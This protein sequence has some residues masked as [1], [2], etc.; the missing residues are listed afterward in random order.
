MNGRLHRAR[1]MGALCAVLVAVPLMVSAGGPGEA[2]PSRPHAPRAAAGSPNTVVVL[3]DDMRAHELR[4]LPRTRNWLARRGVRFDAAY[5]PTPLCCPAR[6][7]LLT[8][9]YAHNTGVYD[10]RPGGIRPGGV[11]AFDDDRTVATELSRRGIETG[12]IGKYLNQY[13]GLWIPPGWTDWR[14][15]IDGH[16]AYRT[17]DGER[18][19]GRN[20]T[21]TY[22]GRTVYNVNGKE[23]TIRG[24]E[25]TVQTNLTTRFIRRNA[26]D[27]FFL[28]V[29]YLAPH[30]TVNG[31]DGGG[32][33]VPHKSHAHDFDGLKAPRTKAFNEADVRDKPRRLR[34]SPMKR[35]KQE[36]LDRAAEARAE[37]LQ[38]VDDGMMAIRRTLSRQ[39]ILRR[40]NVVFVSD[41]GFMLGEHRMSQEK[42]WA[43]E[44]SARVPL[45]MAGPD[46]PGKGERRQVPVGL[47]DLPSTITDWHGLGAMPGADGVPLFNGRLPR[48]DIL[49]QGT[50]ETQADISYTGLR[51]R[52][53]YKYVEYGYGG[54]ELYDLRRD[55]EELRNLAR[56]KSHRSLRARLSHRLDALRD[57]AGRDCWRR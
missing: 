37:T 19:T 12:H 56:D 42:I 45:L 13:R 28:L 53:G 21:S 34:R 6:A 31:P 43:Y 14:T 55:P 27:P 16:Y 10:N 23:R 11:R 52:G 8:G 9:Q 5:A 49:L 22:A 2:Q 50:F 36:R 17:P 40:T 32:P 51:T 29:N 48:R 1:W 18:R 33:P 54:V 47:H 38:S 57:C 3:V 44:P 4:F 15:A 35:K 30:G 46:V 24:Y 41:N 39:G 20:S 25:T 26:D 7:T